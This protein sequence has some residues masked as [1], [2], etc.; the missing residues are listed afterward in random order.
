ML[1]GEKEKGPEDD[2]CVGV[3]PRVEGKASEK[4]R[5]NKGR[6]K[7]MQLGW[8]PVGKKQEEPL[9]LSSDASAKILC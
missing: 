6:R 9:R 7:R 5:A 8:V 4:Q 2:V 3:K 1:A